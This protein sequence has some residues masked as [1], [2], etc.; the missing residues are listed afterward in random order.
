MNYNFSKANQEH[1][2]IKKRKENIPLTGLKST[3]P[4]NRLV[5]HRPQKNNG[6]QGV[7]MR[8]NPNYHFGLD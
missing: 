4:V 3:R 6:S 2:K 1:G 5:N 8:T 7:I